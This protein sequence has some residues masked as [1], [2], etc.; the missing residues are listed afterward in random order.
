MAT[1]VF[2]TAIEDSTIITSAEGALRSKHP[3]LDDGVLHALVQ[4]AYDRLTPAKVHTYLPILIAREVNADLR[5][6]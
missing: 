4:A 5:A 1:Q 6:H 3:E 2:Q